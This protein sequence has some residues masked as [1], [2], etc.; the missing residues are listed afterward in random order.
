M[1]FTVEDDEPYTLA[2]KARDWADPE[3]GYEYMQSD[4]A[5]IGGGGLKVMLDDGTTSSSAWKCFLTSSGPT[6]A[7]QAKGCSESN[8]GACEVATYAEPA[9][10]T[11]AGFDDSMWQNAVEYTDA[12]TGWGRTPTYDEKT[13]ECCC[14]TDPVTGEETSP[15]YMKLDADNCVAPKFLDWGEASFIWTSD[16]Y[17]DNEVL[18]RLEVLAGSSSLSKRSSA[19]AHS[20]RPVAAAAFAEVG[21]T[22]SSTVPLL[23]LGVFGAA[24]LSIVISLYCVFPRSTALK[25]TPETQRL[26]ETK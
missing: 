13:G 17:K 3:T 2:I 6:T 19:P 7:S 5:G 14:M 12:Y 18:C 1:S 4:H 20:G 8:Y 23:L 22:R 15:A 26:V 9:G 16:L 10:W 11:E 24:L 21:S 25:E